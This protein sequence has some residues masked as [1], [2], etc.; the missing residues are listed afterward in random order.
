MRL[1]EKAGVS[2]IVI[3]G[4]MVYLAE[5]LHLPFL[6]P[7]AIGVFGLFG[8]WLGVDT[9]IHGEI[10]LWNRLY[11]RREN[12]SGVPARLL[13]TIIFL[14]GVGVTLYS[15][16]EW[17]QPD[18]AGNFL[19]GLVASN[20][21]RGILLLAFGFFTLLFGLIRL[22]AGSAHRPEERS[23]VVDFFYRARGLV[24][25]VVGVL[26]FVAGVWLMLR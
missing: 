4:G 12:Y 3:A 13:G 10:R 1:I 15:I 2:A 9:L 20:R 19:A 7:I 23:G 5:Y 16:S 17:M 26:L 25:I 22:I 8:V 18:V 6:I 24:N 11:S 14:F 21:G